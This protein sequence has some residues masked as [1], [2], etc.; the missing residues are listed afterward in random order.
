MVTSREKSRLHSAG[1]SAVLMPFR[2]VGGCRQGIVLVSRPADS[3]RND[4]GSLIGLGGNAC[5]FVRPAHEVAVSGATCLNSDD[6]LGSTGGPF[7]FS[8]EM[9][10]ARKEC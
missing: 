2:V 10:A 7:G 3:S 6:R 1:A 5:Q 4:L 9:A 8:S